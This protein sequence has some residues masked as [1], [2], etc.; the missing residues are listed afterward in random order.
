MKMKK[1]TL[2]ILLI[3]IFSILGST[4]FQYELYIEIDSR[5]V[6]GIIICENSCWHE[7]GHAVDHAMG[8]VSRS[9]EFQE[10]I[11]QM[12]EEAW[13]KARGME[14]YEKLEDILSPVQFIIMLFP[15]VSDNE[16]QIED[17]FL[18][19]IYGD[20]WGGYGEMYAEILQVSG[21]DP[22]KIPSGLWK[23]Y[24]FGLASEIY[25]IVR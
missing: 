25:Q 19:F 4:E 2:S 16:F 15:G 9:P 18:R 20:S 23:F 12:A 22:E 11:D 6:Q 5:W 21:G 7:T 17:R 10:T 1:K 14:N 3:I 24:D 8:F 13:T